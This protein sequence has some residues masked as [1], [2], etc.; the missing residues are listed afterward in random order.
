M[1]NLIQFP[2]RHAPL[3]KPVLSII[4][5][6]DLEAIADEAGAAL[7]DRLLLSAMADI[8]AAGMSIQIARAAASADDIDPGDVVG[9]DAVISLCLALINV[10]DAQGCSTVDRPLRRMLERTIEQ[11][12]NNNG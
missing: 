9:D 8:A 5:G 11:K 10:I 2:A 1:D 6:T 12:E 4:A 3:P 7:G